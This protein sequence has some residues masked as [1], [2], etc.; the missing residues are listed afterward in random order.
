ME[1]YSVNVGA[2]MTPTSL[3]R[4]VW[5][6]STGVCTVLSIVRYWCNQPNPRRGSYFSNRAFRPTVNNLLFFFGG[7]G[8]QLRGKL[9]NDN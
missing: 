6:V 2:L 3:P 9:T 4:D 1:S 5:G 7:G 8:R